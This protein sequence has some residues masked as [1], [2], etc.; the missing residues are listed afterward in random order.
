[1]KK[2]LYVLIAGILVGGWLYWITRPMPVL[3]IRGRTP[4]MKLKRPYEDL[5]YHDRDQYVEI[6]LGEGKEVQIT[7]YGYGYTKNDPEP[8][9]YIWLEARYREY[10]GYMF[11]DGYTDITWPDG[12]RY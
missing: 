6:W 7:D 10:V 12:R 9:K 2:A 1:M 11:D 4:M 8:Q 5:D 3:E